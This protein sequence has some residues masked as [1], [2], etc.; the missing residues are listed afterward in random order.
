MGRVV[1]Y[2][3][4]TCAWCRKTKR[5]LD[6]L[7]VDYYYVYVDDL[8]SGDKDAVK[9]EVRK[10]NSRCTFP[11]VVVNDKDCVVGF[12]EAKVKEALGL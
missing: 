12:D 2:A 9:E 3:I 11:T 6:A 8:P 1:L 4:S 7:G 10:W 5:L